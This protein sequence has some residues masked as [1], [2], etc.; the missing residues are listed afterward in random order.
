MRSDEVGRGIA[1]SVGS[2][3]L[4]WTRFLNTRA[5]GASAFPGGWGHSDQWNLWVKGTDPHP[6]P[7]IG[8]CGD[9]CPTYEGPDAHLDMP[10]GKYFD[11]YEDTGHYVFLYGADP[12]TG[13][14]DVVPAGSNGYDVYLTDGGVV[15]FTVVSVSYHGIMTTVA[16]SI[17]DP[18]GQVTT[19]SYDSSNR[20]IRVTEPGGRYLQINRTSNGGITGVQAYDGRGNL[21]QTVAYT[22]STLN[23]ANSYGPA[24]Y[25]TQV[26]YDDGSH[27]YYTYQSAN[28]VGLGGAPG[29]IK[30]C[31]DPR[32]AGPMKR[33]EYQFATGN[34]NPQFTWGQIKAEKNSTTHQIVSQ[35]TYPSYPGVNPPTD[36]GQYLRTE[37]RGDG[38]VRTFQYYG[39][40]TYTDFQGHISHNQYDAIFTDARGNVTTI[41]RNR[42]YQITSITHPDNSVAYNQYLNDIYLISHTDERRAYDGDPAYTTYYDRDGN[43]RI[44]RTRYPDG[45]S[46]QFTY[47]NFGEV[48][49]H[50]MSNG[51]VETNTYDGRE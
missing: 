33:I 27:A 25:L 28:V 11:L 34:N 36:P 41:P 16:S 12:K 49:T 35:V 5:V 29:I 37:T 1:G 10:D 23:F 4:K 19:F 6:A 31:D 50:T 51:A 24:P 48:L 7:P 13:L 42:A 44:W 22:Y 39:E 46:E 30:T 3:P 17:A 8:Q 15:H 40:I 26:D 18:Y 9:E 21:T 43:H 14:L 38:A 32:F 20:L 45:S 2:Y 47:N